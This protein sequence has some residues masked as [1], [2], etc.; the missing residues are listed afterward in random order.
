MNLSSI[1]KELKNLT[2]GHWSNVS[3]NQLNSWRLWAKSNFA[4][5]HDYLLKVAAAIALLADVLYMFHISR[6]PE[7]YRGF[8]VQSL[9]FF[10]IILAFCGF[11]WIYISSMAASENILKMLEPIGAKEENCEE[12]LLLCNIPEINEYRLAVLAQNRE[13]VRRDLEL[14]RS[15]NKSLNIKSKDKSEKCLKLHTM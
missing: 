3:Q 6:V 2:P 10:F 12:A 8:D 15:I 14:M 1:E 5:R 4:Y 13:L 11:S 7:T 9:I